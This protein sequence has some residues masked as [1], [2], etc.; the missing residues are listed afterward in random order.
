M[1]HLASTRVSGRILLVDADQR[2]NAPLLKYLRSAGYDVEVAQG[3]Q[4]DPTEIMAAPP[5]VLLLSFPEV[6]TRVVSLC[7]SMSSGPWTSGAS[8]IVL[9]ACRSIDD[10]LKCFDAGAQDVI[11][12]PF[13]LEEVGAR[14]RIHSRYALHKM[15]KGV[16]AALGPLP[17]SKE[18][19]LFDKGIKVIQQNG[20][21]LVLARDLAKQLGTNLEK[22]NSIFQERTG[23]SA[24]RYA[25]E[26]RF[27]R[28]KQILANTSLNIQQ[29]A[30]IAGYRNASDFSR[31]FRS[32]FGMSPK[33]YRTK[34][35]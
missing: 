33:R 14:I 32:R 29:V 1:N 25:K 15:S 16:P 22:L 31:A 10:K 30:V 4:A 20:S 5:H 12:K 7:E 11:G 9:A 6:D 28:S 34:K 17:A 27:E 13:H 3:I 19:K 24:H 26:M 23:K 18:D 21:S 8:V 35:A 2:H